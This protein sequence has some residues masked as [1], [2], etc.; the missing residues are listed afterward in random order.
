MGWVLALP[1]DQQAPEHAD[2]STIADLPKLAIYAELLQ[3]V[4]AAMSQHAK[5]INKI[6]LIVPGAML[7]QGQ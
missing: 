7:N 3:A 4:A 6:A 1:G 2:G 5:L